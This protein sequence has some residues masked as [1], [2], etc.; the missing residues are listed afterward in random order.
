MLIIL[1]LMVASLNA[2]VKKQ[3]ILYLGIKQGSKKIEFQHV[4]WASSFCILLAGATSL[5]LD[6]R[7]GRWVLMIVNGFV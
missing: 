4:I 3:V 5:G 7:K 6:E 1:F 2:L